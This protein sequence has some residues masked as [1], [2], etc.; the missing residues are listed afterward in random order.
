MLT[1][2]GGFSSL[3]LEYQHEFFV[4]EPPP[5]SIMANVKFI[6]ARAAMSVSYVSQGNAVVIRPFGTAQNYLSWKGSTWFTRP[7]AGVCLRSMQRAQP[8][9]G[10]CEDRS[11]L[12][13]RLQFA[14][15]L[16]LV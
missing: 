15:M 12:I 14:S 16:I 1:D 6:L 13:L 9:Y 8:A 4:T 7:T 5:E 11:I 3:P 10:S 2:V